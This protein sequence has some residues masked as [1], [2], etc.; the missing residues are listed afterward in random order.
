MLKI[1]APYLLSLDD[2]GSIFNALSDMPMHMTDPELLLRLSISYE[3]IIDELPA[4][5]QHYT[6]I[7]REQ[8]AELQQR[9]EARSAARAGEGANPPPM[10]TTNSFSRLFSFNKKGQKAAG[11]DFVT[12]ALFF[13]VVTD[14]G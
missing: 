5:R 13:A 2:A 6:G 9:R 7:L 8:L 10:P 4:K 11:M 3:H 14:R 12:S 1:H